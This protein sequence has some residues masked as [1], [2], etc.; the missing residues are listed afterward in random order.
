MIVHEFGKSR[1]LH[2]TYARAETIT[3]AVASV[4]SMVYSY[5][6]DSTDNSTR[7]ACLE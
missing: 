3:E 7:N 1:E 2:A 5:A 6:L 4:A